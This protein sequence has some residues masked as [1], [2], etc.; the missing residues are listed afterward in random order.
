MIASTWRCHSR[1]AGWSYTDTAESSA[2]TA[3][4]SDGYHGY[5]L[6]RS[7]WPNA[8]SKGYHE[9]AADRAELKGETKDARPT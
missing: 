5:A 4:Y 3:G 9:G 6:V 1:L 7:D 8:Y 2:Y